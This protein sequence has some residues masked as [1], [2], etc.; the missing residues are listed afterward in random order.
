MSAASKYDQL[1][2]HLAASAL[3]LA[4]RQVFNPADLD[5]GDAGPDRAW[6]VIH[7]GVRDTISL[8][9]FKVLD[10]KLKPGVKTL[11]EG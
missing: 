4:Q 1:P 11:L 8:Q 3:H 7:A 6:R 5:E 2:G 10:G 9:F